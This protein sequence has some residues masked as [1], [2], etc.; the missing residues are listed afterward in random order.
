MIFAAA[1]QEHRE[2][3]RGLDENDRAEVIR[4]FDQALIE[5]VSEAAPVG[6]GRVARFDHRFA[7]VELERFE[8]EH[9]CE[10]QPQRRVGREHHDANGHGNLRRHPAHRQQEQ[11]DN[12]IGREDVAVPEEH[13]MQRA[14]H[15]QSEQSSQH[16]SGETLAMAL[17]RQHLQYEA[18][19]EQ[20]REQD[21]ELVLEQQRHHPLCCVVEPRGRLRIGKPEIAQIGRREVGDVDDQDPQQGEPA[22][23]VD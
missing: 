17:G 7:E 12:G 10:H 3:D 20:E 13:R 16:P 23:A 2:G 11:S 14:D 5:D 21:V 15:E 6:R 22:Q 19:A 1:E 4:Q 9:G 8:R 18:V